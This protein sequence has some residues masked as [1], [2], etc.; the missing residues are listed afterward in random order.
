MDFT[1]SLESLLGKRSRVLVLRALLAVP[2]GIGL[3][4][5]EVARRTGI[6]HPTA[7]STLEE[8]ASE[9]AV[10]VRRTNGSASYSLNHDHTF[11]RQVIPLFE[12]ENSLRDELSSFLSEE[13]RRY[14]LNIELAILFGSAVTAEVT[15]GS[16]IDLLIVAGDQS[17]QV[18]N[19]VENAVERISDSM[20]LRFG[21]ALSP[22]V[23]DLS[24]KEF[25]RKARYSRYRFWSRVLDTGVV[26]AGNLEDEQRGQSKDRRRSSA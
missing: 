18:E 19:A 2:E 12:W 10:L 25:L 24:K 17:Q 3:S 16:D 15:T 5:R 8:L 7:S 26:I 11:V 4:G 13:V 9:G 1:R 22:I 23:L 20:R 21:N 14:L 6:S